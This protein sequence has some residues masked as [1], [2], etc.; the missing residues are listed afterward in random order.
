MIEHQ[1][2]LD[3]IDLI[4]LFF[5][6]IGF[7]MTRDFPKKWNLDS[8]YQFKPIKENY[9]IYYNNEKRLL[10]H[11]DVFIVG[12]LRFTLSGQIGATIYETVSTDYDFN[13][14]YEKGQFFKE[15]F[16]NFKLNYLLNENN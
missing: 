8:S 15:E 11:V 9:F 2:I 6:S 3:K 14:S 7:K 10:L 5:E 16:R 12:G 1:Q 13:F 4:K